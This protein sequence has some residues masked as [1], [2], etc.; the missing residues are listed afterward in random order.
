MNRIIFSI[1]CV[2]ACTVVIALFAHGP[3]RAEI[4]SKSYVDSLVMPNG[5]DYLLKDGGTMKG[6]IAMDGNKITGLGTPTET[7]DGATKKYVDDIA[8][9]SAGGLNGTAP[10]WATLNAA[11][12]SFNNSAHWGVTWEIV[13]SDNAYKVEGIA[14]CLGADSS[15]T[16]MSQ[17]SVVNGK[18]N[19]VNYGQ[20]CFCRVSRVNN[21]NVVGAWVF[22]AA[23]GSDASCYSYCAHNCGICVHRNNNAG[24]TRVKLFA[25]G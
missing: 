8:A 15:S 7:T 1:L 13:T 19:Q 23:I 18:P 20:N 22:L 11:N 3:V 4:A 14:A 2:F 12:A 17:A 21:Q 24:C 6:E 10:S 9:Q 25:P 16:V 5:D